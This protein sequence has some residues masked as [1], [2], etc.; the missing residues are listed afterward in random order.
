MIESVLETSGVLTLAI[1]ANLT[2][3]KISRLPKPYWIIGFVLP[4]LFLV[5]VVIPRQIPELSFSLPF[6]WTT[7]GRNEFVILS[8][9]APMLMGV[10]IP[11]IPQ[12]RVKVLLYVFVT[13]ALI[14]F[15]VF[16]F[17]V[18]GLLQNK[19]LSLKTQVFDGVCI[20]SNGYNCGP[21]SAVTALAKFGIQAEEGEIAVLAYTT[22]I[23]G[24][25]G[26]LLCKA[27]EKKYGKE[28]ISCE[29]RLFES[30]SQLKDCCPTIAEIKFALFIDHYITVLEV[31]DDALI[32]G[33]PLTGK[34]TLTYEEFRNK[35]RFIGIVIRKD[36][37][38]LR[39]ETG[40]I[41]H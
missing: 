34:Q 16:P 25:P 27:I 10:L 22:P 14:H 19:H 33:D 11:R 13:I 1:A 12:M 37:H 40:A 41:K 17:L 36:E 21:A 38:T 2:G 35:W 8:F 28:G 30:I 6:Q 32:V 9:V 26:D 4:F 39:M 5:S 7:A 24:T 15:A 3:L 29:H 18:P 31:L 20:Q 23:F